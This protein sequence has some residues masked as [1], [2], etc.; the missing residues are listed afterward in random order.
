MVAL[1]C[2]LPLRLLW[3]SSAPPWLRPVLLPSGRVPCLLRCLDPPGVDL[4]SSL[5][6]GRRTPG[7]FPGAPFGWRLSSAFPAVSPPQ[8]LASLFP[9]RPSHL[10]VWASLW[11]PG[12]SSL[13]M[14]IWS[15]L[16]CY[17]GFGILLRSYWAFWM[18]ADGPLPLWLEALPWVPTFGTSCVSLGLPPSAPTGLAVPPPAS[19]GGWSSFWPR[20]SGHSSGMWS[21]GPWD[22]PRVP[23][24]WIFL[25]SRSGHPLRRCSRTLGPLLLS[26]WCGVPS[27]CGCGRVPRFALPLPYAVSTVGRSPARGPVPCAGTG[28]GLLPP[29]CSGLVVP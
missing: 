12:L 3:P 7:S 14:P 16:P 8:W 9:R 17:P 29:A 21:A 26:W 20:C 15:T 23:S 18:S 13:G 27:D 5:D 19:R 10:D 6:F 25:S 24:R 11:A 4:P 22:S 28:P 2:L 1:G